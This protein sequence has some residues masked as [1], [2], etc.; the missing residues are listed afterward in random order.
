MKNRKKSKLRVSLIKHGRGP[1]KHVWDFLAMVISLLI[2]GV[3]ISFLQ[4]TIKAYNLWWIL[5][6]IIVIVSA[7]FLFVWQVVAHYVVNIEYSDGRH[8]ATYCKYSNR[9]CC[10]QAACETISEKHILVPTDEELVSLKENYSLYPYNY[11]L[12]LEKDFKSK[13]GKEIWIISSNLNSEVSTAPNASEMF[14]NI[15]DNLEKG[16]HYYYLYCNDSEDPATIE[17]N[18]RNIKSYTGNSSNVTF[19]PFCESGGSLSEYLPYIFG[20]VIY[21]KEDDSYEGYFAIRNHNRLTNQEPIYEKM[22]IC[23]AGKYLHYMKTKRDDNYSQLVEPPA[24]TVEERFITL[25]NLTEDL[26]DLRFKTFVEE[27]SIP[28]NEEFEGEEERFIH[29]CLYE[30]DLLIAAARVGVEDDFVRISRVVVRT[31]YRNRGKGK[32]VMEFAEEE[33][34]KFKKDKLLVIAQVQAHKFYEKLGYTVVGEPFID[35]GFPH[36]RMIKP[37]S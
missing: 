23:M 13:E 19:V 34:K 29:C 21:V 25:H 14:S 5:V 16:V 11:I 24:G 4:D 8:L 9:H 1:Q 17:R 7:L 27:Q 2:D 18:I 3:V 36:V 6:F 12:E 37:I 35:A 26:H 32:L 28:Y 33:A 10:G 30:N 22:P 31:G 15:R 20:V